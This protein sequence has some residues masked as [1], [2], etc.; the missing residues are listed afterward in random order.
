MG[1]VATRTPV[2]L[3]CD[4][5]PLTFIRPHIHHGS[6]AVAGVVSVRVVHETGVAVQIGGNIRRNSAIVPGVDA[7]GASRQVRVII[8]RAR[9]IVWAVRVSEEWIITDISI[10]CIGI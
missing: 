4:L 3:H 2:P 8:H 10:A 5:F 6:R 9:L 1:S 7:W